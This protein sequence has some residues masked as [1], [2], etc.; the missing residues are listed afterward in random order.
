MNAALAGMICSVAFPFA[1]PATEAVMV[2]G[3]IRWSCQRLKTAVDTEV[4]A[5]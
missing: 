3:G 4:S 1:P 2:T 5:R